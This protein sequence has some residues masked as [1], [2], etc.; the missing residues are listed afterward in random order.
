MR[1]KNRIANAAHAFHFLKGGYRYI[2]HTEIRNYLTNL[3]NEG[4][5]LE[6]YLQTSRGET[7]ANRITTTDDD[8][9][10]DFKANGFLQ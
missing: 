10:L 7:F 4:I 6:P 5:C 9:R 2:Q 8:A 3:L 1:I